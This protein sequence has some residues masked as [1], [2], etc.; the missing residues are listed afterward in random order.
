MM[1]HEP[2]LKQISKMQGDLERGARMPSRWG[3][4]GVGYP[5][6][7]EKGH[8]QC[9]IQRGNNPHHH[10]QHQEVQRNDQVIEVYR[11]DRRL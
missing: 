10:Q 5:S 4:A 3:G 2:L 1:A 7:G 6:D 9:Q 11:S 8:C